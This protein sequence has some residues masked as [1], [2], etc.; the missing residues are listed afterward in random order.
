MAKNVTKRLP[1][2]IAAV[3][4]VTAIFLLFCNFVDWEK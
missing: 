1:S 4:T 2:T 3:V